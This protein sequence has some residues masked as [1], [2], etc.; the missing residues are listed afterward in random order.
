MSVATAFVSILLA[1]VLTFTAHATLTG[2]EVVRRG[3]IEVGFPPSLLWLL[4]LA[5]G[6]GALGIVVGLWWPPLGIAAATCLVVYFLGA[7][8]AHLRVGHPRQA[9]PSAVILLVA[10]VTLALALATVWA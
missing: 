2:R 1:L 4:G 7:A 3:V 8:G 5:Q 6:A 10:I 9:I